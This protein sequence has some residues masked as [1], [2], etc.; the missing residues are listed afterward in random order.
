MERGPD[1]RDGYNGES[2]SV[3][4]FFLSYI[5]QCKAGSIALQAQQQS[6]HP[7]HSQTRYLAFRYLDLGPFVFRLSS[8]FS[9]SS[10]PSFFGYPICGP[11]PKIGPLTPLQFGASSESFKGAEHERCRD[12]TGFDDQSVVLRGGEGGMRIW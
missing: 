3:N 7:V 10:S 5:P 8:F 11:W 9:L 1:W 2:S 6:K 4:W 12:V